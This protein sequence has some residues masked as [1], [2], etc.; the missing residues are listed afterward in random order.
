MSLAGMKRPAESD[1]VQWPSQYK[2]GHGLPCTTPRAT[3]LGL[4]RVPVNPEMQV[5]GC[6][7]KRKQLGSFNCCH[8]WHILA[9]ARQSLCWCLIV[10][11]RIFLLSH[12]LDWWVWVL[13][14]RYAWHNLSVSVGAGIPGL[15]KLSCKTCSNTVAS[16]ANDH[17]EIEMFT[18]ASFSG[19]LRLLFTDLVL[20]QK[21]VQGA[22]ALDICMYVCMY[23]CEH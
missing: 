22:L 8:V 15:T 10:Q 7:S 20:G 9:T 4:R 19:A 3:I 21:R 18:K 23:V 16:S 1:L 17:A 14:S 5:Q 13:A 12:G 6:V 2:F 11:Q